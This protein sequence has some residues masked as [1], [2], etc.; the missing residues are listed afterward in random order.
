[1]SGSPITI[2]LDAPFKIGLSASPGQ[3]SI[4]DTGFEPIG[5]SGRRFSPT[6]ETP[7]A[8]DFESALQAAPPAAASQQG[9]GFPGGAATPPFAAPSNQAPPISFPPNGASPVG[10]QQAAPGSSF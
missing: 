10:E 8:K 2:R 9:G 7:P 1:M 6:K 4:I 3:D 5:D